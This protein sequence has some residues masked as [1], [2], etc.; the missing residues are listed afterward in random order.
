MRRL[1]VLAVGLSEL[2]TMVRDALML[3]S[4]SKLA[5][6]GN[7]SDLCSMSLCREE[8][9]VA[10]LKGQDSPQEQR[11]RAKYIR[12]TWPHAAILLVGGSSEVLEHRLYDERVP[13]SIGPDD[14]LAVIDRLSWGVAV[15]SAA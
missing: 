13:S 4:H 8:F 3:R 15:E 6:V 5:V 7:Y 11:R 14:L 2:A 9:Q 10:V 12:R 1:R